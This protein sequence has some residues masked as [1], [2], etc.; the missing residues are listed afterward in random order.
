MTGLVA[1]VAWQ[2]WATAVGPGTWECSWARSC[3]SHSV[4]VGSVEVEEKAWTATSV[5]IAS[6]LEVPYWHSHSV[7]ASENPNLFDPN[8]FGLA[9]FPS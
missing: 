7:V 9:S 4:G 1:A 5:N 8:L 3:S 2:Q 6:S